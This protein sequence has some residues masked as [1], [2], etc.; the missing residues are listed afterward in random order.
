MN[1]LLVT[2]ATSLALLAC[3]NNATTD[4]RQQEP[5]SEHNHDHDS[6]NHGEIKKIVGIAHEGN[7]ESGKITITP[8]HGE[9]AKEYDYTKSNFDQIAAW[10][11]GDTVTIFIEHHHHG[12]HHHES[13]TKIRIGDMGCTHDHKEHDHAHEGHSHQH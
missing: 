7:H 5:C 10:L 8:I 12:N 2:I 13:I 3:S 11:P 9:Q 1:K 4:K 6:H